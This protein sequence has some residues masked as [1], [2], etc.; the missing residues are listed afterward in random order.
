MEKENIEKVW[1]LTKV[2]LA[3]EEPFFSYLLNVYKVIAT[4]RVPTAGVNGKGTLLINEKWFLERSNADRIFIILHEIMHDVLEHVFRMEELSR[5]EDVNRFI[6]NLVGDRI[7]N[8]SL[9]RAGY[10]LPS[11]AVQPQR[12]DDKI[13]IITLYKEFMREKM[14]KI[15][16]VTDLLPEEDEEEG[17]KKLQDGENQGDSQDDGKD[18]K[19]SKEWNK[20]QNEIQNDE[21]DNKKCKTQDNNQ[22]GEQNKTQGGKSQDKSS[23]KWDKTQGGKSQCRAT[24]NSE[25]WGKIIKE[26]VI[27]AKQIG[28]VPRGLEILI[29]KLLT[30]KINWKRELRAYITPLMGGRYTFQRP[31]QRDRFL[32]STLMPRDGLIANLIVDT[33]GSIS[34]GELTAF[35]TEIFG[36][37]KAFKAKL[38]IIQ[39]DA[40]VQDDITISK[41][42][43]IPTRWKGGGGT[44]FTEAFELIQKSRAQVNIVLTDGAIYD[45]N[46]LPKPCAKT[47]WLVVNNEDFEP[48][49]G[50]V[51]PLRV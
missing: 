10:G 51:L 41:K 37:M 2:K 34:E 27:I 39:C 48:P 24:R 44:K 25:E 50:R 28:L 16:V 20:I 21:Q 8:A 35:V 9:L 33:S 29:S 15:N 6:F 1:E 45:L 12:D 19:D 49:F 22:D 7:V 5:L 14:R 43:E 17:D 3:V 38:R 31:R 4:D 40:E 23:E 47:I 26:K 46:T 36:I 32:I 11:D 18:S 13:D 42:E 30:P